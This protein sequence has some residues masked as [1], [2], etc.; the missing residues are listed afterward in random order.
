MNPLLRD[1]SVIEY[2]AIRL[3]ASLYCS[4]KLEQCIDDLGLRD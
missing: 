4:R 1:L 3:L 2:M